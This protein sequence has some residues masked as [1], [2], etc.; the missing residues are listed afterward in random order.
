[1]SNARLMDHFKLAAQLLV[2]RFSNRSVF[3]NWHDIV[4]IPHYVKYRNLGLRQ[5]RQ[6]VERVT[7]I[8]Q[9]LRFCETVCFQA[10]PPVLS[11][12]LALAFA[13][14]PAFKI[15]HWRIAID[16]LHFIRIRRCPVINNQAAARHPLQYWLIGKEMLKT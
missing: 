14:R 16:R 12:A 5:Q 1:M 6:I 15:H 7:F 9:R 4:G 10:D 11:R 3:C 13:A 8:C 2:A